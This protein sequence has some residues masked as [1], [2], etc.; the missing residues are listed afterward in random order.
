MTILRERKLFTIVLI[1]SDPNGIAFVGTE[2]WRCVGTLT[3][4]QMMRYANYI[5]LSEKCGSLSIALRKMLP[6]NSRK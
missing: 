1:A 3:K 4:T 6:R 5:N 2:N